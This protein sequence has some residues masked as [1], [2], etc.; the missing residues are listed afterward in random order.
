MDC[1]VLDLREDRLPE[2]MAP[3]SPHDWKPC[4]RNGPSARPLLPSKR[5]PQRRPNPEHLI[6]LLPRELHPLEMPEAS[7]E[8][9]GKRA[10]KERD[11]LVGMAVDSITHWSLV[12]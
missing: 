8:I 5:H 9:E 4:E 6:M 7:E 12:G 11:K 2:P 1:L 3:N 10:R